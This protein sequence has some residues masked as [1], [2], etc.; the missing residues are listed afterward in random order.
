M[1]EKH[2]YLAFEVYEDSAPQDW[3]RIL[4][5]THGMYC[6]S[7]H[8]GEDGGKDHYHCMYCHGAATTDAALLRAVPDGIAANGKIEIVTH[9]RGYMRYLIHLDDPEK[10]QFP[11]GANHIECI[12]G[13]PLDLTKEYTK[14]ER[15]EQRMRCLQL[16]QENGITEYADLI[17]GLM[18]TGQHE[19]LDYAC[20]HTILFTGYLTSCRYRK[21]YGVRDDAEAMEE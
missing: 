17:D 12:N 16:I 18:R 5:D 6:R 4:K 21:G 11:D 9:P 8:A 20:N 3:W 19:L 15:N 10:E 7:L 1:A 14:A 2:R 13:F